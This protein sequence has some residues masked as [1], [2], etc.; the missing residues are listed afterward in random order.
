MFDKV[1]HQRLLRKVS[2]PGMDG[3]ILK[4]MK[5]CFSDRRQRAVI[6]GSNLE[7]SQVINGVP[8]ESI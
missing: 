7:W 2:V 6:N 8:Q 1:L 3:K 5:S 4:W